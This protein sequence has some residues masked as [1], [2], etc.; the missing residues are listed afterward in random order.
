MV[1]W[2]CIRWPWAPTCILHQ[3]LCRRIWCFPLL[4]FHCSG[5]SGLCWGTSIESTG[6]LWMYPRRNAAL[7]EVAHGEVT[8]WVSLFESMGADF[9]GSPFCSASAFGSIP[10]AAFLWSGSDFSVQ[11]REERLIQNLPCILNMFRHVGQH[12]STTKPVFNWES[13]VSCH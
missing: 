7:P 12:W 10:P 8:P 11:I 6:V 9:I 4:K 13:M 3:S 1:P 5:D 2:K